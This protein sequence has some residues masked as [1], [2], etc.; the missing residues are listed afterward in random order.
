MIPSIVL[1]CKS[2]CT[3]VHRVKI[4][5][6]S[7]KKYNVESIPFYISVPARDV[8]LFKSI[9]GID[10]YILLTDEDILRESSISDSWDVQ[11][12]VKIAFWETNL[13]KNYL[14]LDSDSYFIRPF[15]VSDFIASDKDAIPYTVMHEQHELF[16]WT[17][18]KI[19]HLGFDPQK[20]FVECR[21]KIMDIFG[22]SGKIYDFGPSPVIWSCSVWNA[23]T[24]KYLIPNNLSISNLIKM[25]A[26]EFS[27]Y[28]Q[29]LLADQT[30]P[31]YPTEPLFKVFHYGQQYVE[32][33]QQGYTEEDFS[34]VKMG[35]IM[36]GNWGAPIKY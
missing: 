35:I 6:A 29:F 19:K 18:N 16:L 11:Q 1:F 33:K 9:L 14:V 13:G 7:V 2:Y 32:A 26:S 8:S 36:Q 5:L 15:T 17:T 25:S 20:S 27:W 10:G 23:L 31:I 30:I 21:K 22:Q 12:I 4:L 34:R 3:D 28:G 24:E